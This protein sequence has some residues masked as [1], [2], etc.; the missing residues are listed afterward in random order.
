MTPLQRR[1]REQPWAFD[2]SRAVA[3]VGGG[4]PVRL[5][6]D[7]SLAMPAAEVVAAETDGDGWRLTLGIPGLY[8]A[9]SPLPSSYTEDLFPEEE[10]PLR[11]GVV[12]LINDRVLHL[13]VQALRRERDPQVSRD[14]LGLATGL[15][16]RRFA[17]RID[18]DDLL[19]F[20][21]LLG[22]RARGA[23]GLERLLGGW[24]GVACTVEEC[25]PL[26]TP[27][28]RDQQ[29]SLGGLNT[30]LGSTTIAGEAVVSRATAFRV[31]V[32]PLPWNAVDPWLPG[33]SGLAELCTLTDLA[34]TDALDYEIVLVV[35]T[36]GM[37]NI[38]LGDGRLGLDTRTEGTMDGLRRELVFRTV[39]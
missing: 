3:V 28:P 17:D 26:L 18:G 21:G 1:L 15:A 9:G 19:A 29:T 4:G 31:V 33:G 34:N 25:I 11:R 8:G 20:A 37:P 35:E 39:G 30:A 14:L 27:I 32:G 38:P 36:A 23:D 24:S 5:R 7:L 13:L 2:L 22:G 16:G 6:P 12:D 10:D